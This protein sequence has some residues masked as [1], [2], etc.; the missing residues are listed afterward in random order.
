MSRK[1]KSRAKHF[2]EEQIEKFRNDPN[3]RYV[4]DH[5]LRFTFEFRTE[6]YEAWEKKKRA[7]IKECLVSHGYDL[8]ELGSN[9][10][11]S[12]CWNFVVNGRPSN[13]KNNLPV[14][15]V[16]SFKTSPEDNEYLISTGK[17][18]RSGKGITFSD[19]FKNELFQKYPEQ[20][21][22][23]GIRNAGIDPQIV[24]HQR[25]YALQK[26]FSGDTT[27]NRKA[28]NSEEIIEKY[29]DHPYVQSVTSK[30]FKF[31]K[32]FLNEASFLIEL[33][34]V[35]E[36]LEMYEIDPNDLN[37]SVKI[38]L[39]YRLSHWKKTEE[40][41]TDITE[42]LVRIQHRRYQK[43]SVL[44]EERFRKIREEE[45]PL[46]TCLQKKGLCYWIQGFPIDPQKQFTA[47]YLLKKCGISH[48]SYYAILKNNQY[49]LREYRKREE[50]ER[51]IEI[52]KRVMDYR[53]FKKGVRQIYM[54]MFDITAEQFSMKKIK[55]LM[56]KYDL[57]CDIR[58]TKVSRAARRKLIEEHTKPNLLERRFRLFRP[59]TVALSDVTYIPYGEN[60][61]AYGSAIK[62]A[63]SGRIYDFTIME[64]NTLEFV[65]KSVSS[66]EGFTFNKD[67]IFHS[68]QGV[69]YMTDTFQ[70]KIKDLKFQ[71]SMSRRG[72]CWDNASQESFFGHF[73]DECDYK[74]CHDIIEL[75]VM[76]RNYIDYYNNERKQWNRNRMTPVQYEAY[77][78]SM[79]EEEFAVYLEKEEQKYEQMKAEAVE[80][81]RKRALAAGI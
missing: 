2:T 14:G 71:Q 54:M 19:A 51:D 8:E 45:V 15:T 72:N 11:G 69:L 24:G 44:M 12:F 79:S 48:S 60:K 9:L 57:H 21:I 56:K 16:R 7:G 20:S 55:R 28:S 62:D 73:K 70:E 81:A 58:E 35:N 3:V 17:F 26:L 59:N 68:D 53:G 5:T 10:I 27:I 49:G 1:Q 30:Q 78:N 61:L 64:Y 13:A 76:C 32:A 34:A 6:L 33:I 74:A 63:V 47:E 25:I 50:D 42:Q 23:E 31:R 37:N 46:L 80:K 18:V 75:Q 65:M 41:F 36:I 43:L 4:D 29:K 66:L 22:E 52:I 40:R 38:N 67:A 39:K 77:L